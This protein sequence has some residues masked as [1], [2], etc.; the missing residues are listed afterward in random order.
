MDSLL[1]EREYVTAY[2]MGLYCILTAGKVDKTTRS[3][4]QIRAHSI[5]K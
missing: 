2:T 3:A 1:I 4:H 5:N